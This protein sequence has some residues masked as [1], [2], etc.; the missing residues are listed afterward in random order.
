MTVYT[1]R[2]L[3][4]TGIVLIIVSFLVFIA[5]RLLPGDPVLIYL[6]ETENATPEKIAQLRTEF[7]LDK[8]I[9]IQYLN[10]VINA[11]Q[12]DF[13]KSIYYDISAI[14]L[15]AE[16]LPVTIYLC[17]SALL[18]SAVAGILA[19][20]I[21]A[22]RRGTYLDNVLTVLANLG[23]TIPKFWLGFLLIYL[24]GYQLGWLPIHGYTHPWDDF[25]MSVK[26][27]IMPALSLCC[28]AISST[29]RITRSS[30]LEVVQQDYIRTAWAKGLAERTIV[31]RHVLRNGLITI[32][33]LLGVNV[34]FL[35]GQC[36]V[37]EIVFNMPGLGRL[38]VESIFRQ[39]Y[40]ALQGASLVVGLFIVLSNFIVDISYG[41]IDPR[42]RQE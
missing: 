19:G 8:P 10:W 36:V 16:A 24:F 25:W 4:H 1:L 17:L 30:I 23:V 28:F 11:M 7:G 3:I 22:I 35:L 31:F 13:G 38:L 29:T 5:V 42:I 27:M 6:N 14:S 2:K 33:T 9:P 41:W 39:D 32:V 12:G 37:I 20:L 40:I 15:I 21:C 26:Q 18:I 34:R